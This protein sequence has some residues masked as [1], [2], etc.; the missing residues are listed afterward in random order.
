MYNSVWR[1]DQE[2]HLYRF[3]W[4]ETA[5]L[6]MFALNVKEHRVLEEDCYVDGISTYNNNQNELHKITE[7]VQKILRA[8]GF[9]LKPWVC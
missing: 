7:E 9:F 5:K 4:R 2:M 6:T 8:G 3:L 1:E